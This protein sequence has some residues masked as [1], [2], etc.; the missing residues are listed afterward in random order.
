MGLKSTILLIVEVTVF[1]FVIHDVCVCAFKYICAGM[2][3]LFFFINMCY[4]DFSL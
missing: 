4:F 3:H 2:L 1:D